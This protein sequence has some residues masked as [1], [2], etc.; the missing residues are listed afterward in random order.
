MVKKI[1]TFFG[2]KIHLDEKVTFWEL[3]KV[4][5]WIS[6][7]GLQ[8]FQSPKIREIHGKLNFECKFGIK[9]GTI[10]VQKFILTKK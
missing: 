7:S 4:K 1:G 2:L 6:K 3:Y 8:R 10:F 9:T 5:I